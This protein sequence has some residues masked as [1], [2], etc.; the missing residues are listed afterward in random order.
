MVRLLHA[1]LHRYC[2][3]PLGWPSSFN[4]NFLR[5]FVR[6]TSIPRSSRLAP[7]TMNR[8]EEK[9]EREEKVTGPGWPLSLSLP[10]F[11]PV[12]FARQD[13]PRAIFRLIRLRLDEPSIFHFRVPSWTRQKVRDLVSTRLD[14]L[15]FEELAPLGFGGKFYRSEKCYRSIPGQVQFVYLSVRN[16]RVCGCSM[17]ENRNCC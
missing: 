5:S 15:A 14:P 12:A 1:P 11:L 10:L 13:S 3:D 7:A 9:K 2:A 8:D 16:T 6:R 4:A 17:C